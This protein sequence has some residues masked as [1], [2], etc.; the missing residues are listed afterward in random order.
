MLLLLIEGSRCAERRI[1]TCY[2]YGNIRRKKF[3]FVG[4]R[5][6]SDRGVLGVLEY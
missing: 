6:W 5:K 3:R 1:E 4:L 2:D